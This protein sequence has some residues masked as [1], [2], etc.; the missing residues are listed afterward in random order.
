MICKCFRGHVSLRHEFHWYPPCPTSRI[1]AISWIDVRSKHC[2]TARS[3]REAKKARK[4]WVRRHHSSTKQ[5]PNSE[6][7][8]NSLKSLPKK[9]LI[10]FWLLL[11]LWPLQSLGKQFGFSQPCSRWI[12]IL[13]NSWEIVVEATLQN[14]PG[15]AEKNRNKVK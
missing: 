13:Q 7:G 4:L 3:V 14:S 12:A 1:A 15:D 10:L 11:D 2:F 5:I 9:K 8:H 6:L